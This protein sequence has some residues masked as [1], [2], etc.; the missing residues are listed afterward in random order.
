MPSLISVPPYLREDDLV[1]L[2]DVHLDVLAVLVARARADGE[3]A[4]ALRL[5]LRGVRQDDAADR[6]LLLLEDLDD[7]AVAKGCRFI[8]SPPLVD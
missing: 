3:D 6:R 1:A 4:A 2:V 5:L 8:Q 7:Q